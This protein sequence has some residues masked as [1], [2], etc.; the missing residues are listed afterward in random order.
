MKTSDFDYDL[1]ESLIA[2]QPLSKRDGGRLLHVPANAG[3]VLYD[4]HICDLL[5]LAR[6][7]DVWVC[8]NT[9]VIPARLFGHKSS[10]G[11][12]ELLLL[13]PLAE[14]N[15]WLAWG[16]SNKSLKVGMSITIAADFTAEIMHR[17]GKYV[18]V[19]LYAHN[20]AA[21]LQEHGHIPLPPYIHRHDNDNDSER[22]QTVF[23]RHDGAV[24]APTAGLHL[25]NELLNALVKKGVQLIYITLH[26]GPGTFQPVQCNDLQ[27]HDMHDER[28]HISN[29]AAAIINKACDEGRRVVAVGT[30]SLR[31]LEAACIRNASDN[32]MAHVQAGNNRTSLFIY[33][34][35]KFG[36]VSALL[37]N[38]HLPRSTL[39]MLVS[40][41][42]GHERILAAYEY[43]VAQ[44]Y[45]FYSY[46]DAMFVENI[47]QDN[48]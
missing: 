31:T 46:G 8:N 10:G 32:I 2:Q 38:F 6:A 23:A 42:G 15:F 27:N 47:C 28:Y 11:K 41:L 7:G 5:N 24:A 37:T 9:R 36:I 20:V 48:R 45:R 14:T 21:A 43:A 34:S 33:P 3:A 13:E 44:K 12:V 16:K 22:Y 26:I 17:D 19:C 4:K 30:T 40:A 29:E 35:Y 18:H 25:S 39:L 1:D